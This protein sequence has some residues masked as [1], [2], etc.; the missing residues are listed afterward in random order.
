MRMNKA[1]FK[2]PVSFFSH[3]GTEAQSLIPRFFQLPLCLRAS[4]R[5]KISFILLFLSCVPAFADSF[6]WNQA[7]ARLMSAS[8]APDF[9]EAAVLYRSLIDSGDNSPQVFYNYGTALLFADAPDAAIDALLRAERYGGSNPDIRRNLDLAITKARAQPGWYRI[10]FFWHYGL[11]LHIRLEFTLAAFSGVFLCL[12]LRVILHRPSKWLRR[13]L[14][15][16]LATFALFG[17]SVLFSLHQNTQPLPT[18][19]YAWEEEE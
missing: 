2:K 12:L 5:K 13:L 6:L 18:P 14:F 4:V 1:A 15:V 9:A 17:S 8:N 19:V 16:C 10:P 11:S 7:N 3:R